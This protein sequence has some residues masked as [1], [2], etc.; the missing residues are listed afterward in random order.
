MPRKRKETD[1]TVLANDLRATKELSG[2][3]VFVHLYDA[4]DHDKFMLGEDEIVSLRD[5]LNEVIKGENL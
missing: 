1:E 3:F 5:Y 2:G 4:D